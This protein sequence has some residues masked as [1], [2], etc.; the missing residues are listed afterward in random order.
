MKFIPFYESSPEIDNIEGYFEQDS[1]KHKPI[2]TAKWTIRARHINRPKPH[3]FVCNGNWHS[4][5][6]HDYLPPLF[7]ISIRGL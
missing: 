4:I 2:N 6:L 1:P 7:R 3:Y 5:E